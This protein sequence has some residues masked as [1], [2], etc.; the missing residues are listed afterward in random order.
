MLLV[1]KAG[2]TEDAGVESTVLAESGATLE[3]RP[4][5]WREVSAARLG[6]EY[7]QSEGGDSPS[8]DA[9]VHLP[10]CKWARR[11]AGLVYV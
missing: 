6:L 3:L 5:V 7:S 1:V 11:R 8:K 4:V 9:C 10:C 2:M